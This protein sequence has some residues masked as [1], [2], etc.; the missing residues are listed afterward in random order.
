MLGIVGSHGQCQ[1]EVHPDHDREGG[2]VEVE[3]GE[4]FGDAILDQPPTHTLG[5]VADLPQNR[6]TGVQAIIVNPVARLGVV[7]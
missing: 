1:V 3:A 7:G 6:L 4:V 2:L 5:V